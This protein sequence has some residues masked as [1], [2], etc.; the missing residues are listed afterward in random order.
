MLIRVFRP[1]SRISSSIAP[2]AETTEDDLQSI[3]N[4]IQRYN[5][6]LLSNQATIEAQLSQLRRAYLEQL[7]LGQTPL[8]TP[9][10]SERL[11]IPKLLEKYML[12]V[13]YPDN[14]RWMRENGS[15]QEN[16][17]RKR[18]MVNAVEESIR[19][20]MKDVQAEFLMCQFALLVVVP[21]KDENENM[22]KAVERWTM[23]LSVQLQKRFRFGVSPGAERRGEPAS[24]LSQGDAERGAGRGEGKRPLAGYLPE[25]ADSAEPAH[26]RTGL[27]GALQQRVCLL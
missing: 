6:Q 7:A 16:L 1:L 9:E 8:I 4:A 14:G 2:N 11:G 23:D 19:T 12:I 20:Q 3:A 22:A 18:I 21:V 10:Q 17:Y 27:H 25:Y 15:E 24:R 13:L 5:Q 26:V